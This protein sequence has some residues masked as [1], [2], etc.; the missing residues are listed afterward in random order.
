MAS[1]LVASQAIIVQPAFATQLRYP[2]IAPAGVTPVGQKG[3]MIWDLPG[4]SGQNDSGLSYTGGVANTGRAVINFLFNP[5]EI[6]FSASVGNTEAQAAQTYKYA[7]STVV[8]ALPL[9][10][11]A[12][13]TIYY[14][15]TYEL[16][17]GTPSGAQW[18]PSI[19]GVQ[20]DVLAF[21]QF[22]GMLSTASLTT[23]EAAAIPLGQMISPMLSIYSWVYFGTQNSAS[24]S[25]T[26][27]LPAQL[28]YYGYISSFSVEYT[29]FN[30]NMTPRQCEIDVTFTI[31]SPI[32]TNGQSTAYGSVL[33][34]N[35]G[36]TIG[37]YGS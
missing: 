37:S 32:T 31:M 23:S 36:G 34:P 21:Y 18:D 26:N 4:T 24:S 3:Y 2:A 30:Q 25:V 12:S 35:G 28:A 6:D 5:S 8:D 10:Q 11:N 22:T 15:R 20:A 27:A 7:G 14:D 17:N 13:W 19:I 16:W 33:N 1:S 29:A 9:P